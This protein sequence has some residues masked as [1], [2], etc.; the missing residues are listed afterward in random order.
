[1][2]LFSTKKKKK[3]KVLDK[4]QSLLYNYTKPDA[5]SQKA[6]SFFCHHTQSFFPH[7]SVPTGEVF[8]R[9]ML[10]HECL[11]VWLVNPEHIFVARQEEDS[12][13]HV[14]RRAVVNSSSLS[15]QL[16][17][18]GIRACQGKYAH[19]SGPRYKIHSVRTV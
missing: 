3:K 18:R 2:K 9:T 17:V 6:H 8:P 14:S 10:V 4:L 7:T 19:N 11:L 5:A 13:P 16:T 1:M 12:E 15:C